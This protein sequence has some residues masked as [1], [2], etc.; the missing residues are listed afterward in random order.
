MTDVEL[1]SVRFPLILNAIRSGDFSDFLTAIEGFTDFNYTDVF[2]V[3]MKFF[4]YL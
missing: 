1:S 2:F 4:Y 3:F